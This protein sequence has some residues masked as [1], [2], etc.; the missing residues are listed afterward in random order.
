MGSSHSPV[1]A[2]RGESGPGAPENAASENAAPGNATPDNDALLIRALRGAARP[3]AAERDFGPLLDAI[4]DRR[5]VLLGEATHG[6]EDF[7][8]TRAAI[9]KLLI[10]ERGFRA[11]AIEGDWPDARRAHCFA[12]G[13]PYAGGEDRDA[14]QALRG[15]RRFPSWMWRNTVVVEFIAWLR[16]RNQRRW[17]QPTGFYGLDLYSLHASIAAILKF[18]D[19]ADPAAAARARAR[20][21]CFE[22]AEAQSYGYAAGLGLS[23]GCE[24]EAV[25]QLVEMRRRA[26]ELERAEGDGDEVFSALQNARLI[27]N[28]EQYYRAM[29]HG[30]VSTWNLRD[31]HMAE[32]L[33]AVASHT[34]ERA[35]VVVWAHNSHLGDARATEMG[36]GG[37]RN[38]GQMA[39][40]RFGD[41]VFALGFT[42][43]HGWVTAASDWDQEAERKRVRPGLP[44]SFEALFHAVARELGAERFWLPLRGDAWLAS[45]LR[46]PRLERA[47]GVVYLPA[48]ERRSHYFHA[49]LPR[50]FDAV[51]HCDATRALEPLERTSLWE[52]GEPPETYPFAV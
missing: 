33:E 38:L 2:R 13:R 8:Q 43:D 51:I 40:E 25:A 19:R 6:S 46:R 5:F 49:H 11:V 18:L 35:K 32:T 12:R 48:S 36:A 50:Q 20:Y 31:E 52:A 47:I 16:A 26:A 34:G 23:R 3:L 29:F 1:V 42:T 37:E 14:D 10:Q 15:F 27:R 41:D 9:T 22:G 45:A 4:G 17:E 21:G 28:A 44:N 39:R 7:Y 30:R 24:D